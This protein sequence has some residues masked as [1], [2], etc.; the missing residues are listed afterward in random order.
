MNIVK[1]F[2]R[3]FLISLSVAFKLLL[4]PSA[5]PALDAA[6]SHLQNQKFPL[7]FHHFISVV[8]EKIA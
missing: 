5:Q 7:T 8:D 1:E 4:C 2:R 3:H 6:H